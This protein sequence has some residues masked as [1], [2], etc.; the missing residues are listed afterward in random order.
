MNQ[1]NDCPRFISEVA[2]ERVVGELNFQVAALQHDVCHWKEVAN[3][4][5]ARVARQRETLVTYN[6]A[7]VE[8]S[9]TIEKLTEQVAA[10]HSFHQTQS[11]KELTLSL[12]QSKARG[13]TLRTELNFTTQVRDRLADDVARVKEERDRLT[14]DVLRVKQERAEVERERNDAR[15][16]R[17]VL[18]VSCDT[19]VAAQRAL[20]AELAIAVN[21]R[22]HLNDELGRAKKERDESKARV[23]EMEASKVVT[24]AAYQDWKMEAAARLR[25]V[26][27]QRDAYC[28]AA[29]RAIKERDEFEKALKSMTAQRDQ[30]TN[31]VWRAKK[32]RDEFETAWRQALAEQ[33]RLRAL[34]NEV[35]ALLRKGGAA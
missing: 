31:D 19:A 22:D 3:A 34:L 29:G 17:Y 6:D 11:Q 7:N 28:E 33:H 26:E 2:H 30:T 10:L 32:E 15:E 27:M 21:T 1:P 18:S 13:D 23:Q 35:D 16:A 4:E 9:R 14:N 20:Q 5:E 12:A 25:E 8:Q 24:I